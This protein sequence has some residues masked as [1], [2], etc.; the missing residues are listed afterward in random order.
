MCTKFA[1]ESQYFTPCY[2][3]SIR[4]P[5]VPFLVCQKLHS[6]WIEWQREELPKVVVLHPVFLKIKHTLA[7]NT[8]SRTAIHVTYILQIWRETGI[9]QAVTWP[10]YCWWT[11]STTST[12]IMRLNSRGVRLTT[13]LLQ[14]PGPRMSGAVFQITVQ[15]TESK[16]AWQFFM[17]TPSNTKRNRNAFSADA[18]KTQPPD[19]AS[20]PCDKYRVKLGKLT[21]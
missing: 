1:Y 8:L 15:R 11:F 5:K 18:S 13:H 3:Q 14:A 19:T 7:I 2:C 4:K 20:P 17:Y 21:D 12:P 9:K 16:I 6:P 10:G